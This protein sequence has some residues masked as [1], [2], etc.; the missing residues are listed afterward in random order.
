M[1]LRPCLGKC[2]LSFAAI[3]PAC[4]FLLPVSTQAVPMFF[5]DRANFDA[6]TSGLSFES[7]ETFFG[8]T[9][10]PLVF[11]DFTINETVGNPVFVSS[12]TSGAVSDG[13][14]AVVYGSDG[15]S[16]ITIAFNNPINTFGIDIC[17]FGD[18]STFTGSLSVRSDTSSFNQT[19]ATVLPELLTDNTIFFG[20]IEPVAFNSI[21]MKDGDERRCYWTRRS[22][23]RHYTGYC[24]RTG[25]GCAASHRTCGFGFG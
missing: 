12:A 14:R 9:T 19:L 24:S 16:E 2:F 6:A 11:T 15:P 3:F 10:M 8:S 20:V 13:S 18:A 21:V 7:F 17:D 22:F 23:I 25:G 5:S 4:L 1:K